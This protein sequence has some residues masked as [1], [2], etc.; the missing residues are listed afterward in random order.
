MELD[1]E[2][3]RPERGETIV[4]S[5]NMISRIIKRSNKKEYIK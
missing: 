4:S 1:S 3:N 5:V 2:E